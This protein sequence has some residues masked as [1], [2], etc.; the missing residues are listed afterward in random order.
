[1]LESELIKD[2]LRIEEAVGTAHIMIRDLENSNKI[3]MMC[4]EGDEIWGASHKVNWRT[5]GCTRNLDSGLYRII[6]Y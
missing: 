5:I 3:F 1:M 6:F 4:L 2:G